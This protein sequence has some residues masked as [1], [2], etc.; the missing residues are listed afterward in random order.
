[1]PRRL[2][3]DQ[4]KAYMC[5]NLVKSVLFSEKMAELM[6]LFRNGMITNAEVTDELMAE[7]MRKARDEGNSLGL[8]AEELALYGTK[9]GKHQGLLHKSAIYRH[10]AR[11]HR[12]AA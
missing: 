8:N 7:E 5:T 4:I 2:L 10:D 6:K 11:T 3:T 12:N 1:M 9:A